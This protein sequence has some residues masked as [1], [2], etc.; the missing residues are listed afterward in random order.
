MSLLLFLANWLKEIRHINSKTP[1]TLN[2]NR[3]SNKWRAQASWKIIAFYFACKFQTKRSR[4]N[5]TATKYNKENNIVDDENRIR[6]R[7]RNSMW[8]AWTE[9]SRINYTSEQLKTSFFHSSL[10]RWSCFVQF[11]FAVWKM[12]RCFICSPILW[13]LLLAVACCVF[14]STLLRTDHELT[15]ISKHRK[16]EI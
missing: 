3:K 6:R 13:L 5:S 4:K 1:K 11:R 12:L 14:F 16:I 10:Y 7:R 8:S 2:A 15:R 9:N